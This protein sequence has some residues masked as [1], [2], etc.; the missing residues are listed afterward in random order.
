MDEKLTKQSSERRLQAAEKSLASAQTTT[1]C[2][3]DNRK[4]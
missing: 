1:S 2:H 4:H 3:S